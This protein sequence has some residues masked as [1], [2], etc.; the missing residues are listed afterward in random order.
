MG[1]SCDPADMRCPV[2]ATLNVIGGKWKAVL[3]WHLLEGGVLR[4]GELRRLLPGITQ[5]MLTQQL[6]ELEAAGVIS[7][8]VYAEV[9]P[10]VEYAVTAH[11]RSLRPLLEAMHAWG[12]QHC[13]QRDDDIAMPQNFVM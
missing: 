9:P 6:R 12:L 2:E 13:L 11:G 7:R 10:R 3:V 5:K 8:T 1:E 4:F